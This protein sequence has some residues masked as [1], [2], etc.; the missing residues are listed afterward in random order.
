MYV[1]S[2]DLLGRMYES[3]DRRAIGKD[4]FQQAHGLEELECPRLFG[5]ACVTSQY[6][7]A[8]ITAGVGVPLGAAIPG[9]PPSAVSIE[10][11]AG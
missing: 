5:R 2:Y 7:T 4:A 1:D 3:T 6:R 8:L 9:L 10:A 11:Q